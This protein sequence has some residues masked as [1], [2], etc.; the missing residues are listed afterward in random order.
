M[1]GKMDRVKLYEEIY[2]DSFSFGENWKIF[3]QKLNEYKIK[4]AEKSLKEF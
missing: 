1:V 2:K 4:N 3:L